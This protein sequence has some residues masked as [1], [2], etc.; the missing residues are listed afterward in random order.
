MFC[1]PAS[2]ANENQFTTKL[3]D[4]RFWETHHPN[5]RVNRLNGCNFCNQI[6]TFDCSLSDSDTQEV[7]D[8]IVGISGIHVAPKTIRRAACDSNDRYDNEY[9]SGSIP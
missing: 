5:R 8:R 1:F 9:D 4:V 6:D 2:H 3:S 7:I